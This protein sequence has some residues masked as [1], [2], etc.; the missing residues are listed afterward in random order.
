MLLTPKKFEGKLRVLVVREI[1]EIL[2]T[3]Q[4]QRQV[5]EWHRCPQ[6]L[7]FYR[8][9]S[10]VR[11]LTWE[12]HGIFKEYQ[13]AL[14]ERGTRAMREMTEQKRNAEGVGSRGTHGVQCHRQSRGFRF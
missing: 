5:W 11:F 12:K 14:E 13:E 3:E 1:S 10:P 9:K 8:D 2:S 6:A 7:L 4:A